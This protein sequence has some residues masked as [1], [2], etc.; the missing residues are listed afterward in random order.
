M[1]NFVHQIKARMEK[2]GMTHAQLAE[3]AGVSRAYIYRI[4][5]GKQTPSM[6]IAD[7]IAEALG[8]VITTAPAK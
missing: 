8:L 6:E 5:D 1:E 3:A 4:L 7:S 2:L